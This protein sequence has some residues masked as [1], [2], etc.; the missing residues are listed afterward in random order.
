MTQNDA[1]FEAQEQGIS[2]NDLPALLNAY[3][4]FCKQKKEEDAKKQAELFP[5]LAGFCRW[6]G[7]GTE[8]FAKLEKLHPRLCDR[9]LAI[10]EDEALNS[11]LSSSTLNAYLKQR[12]WREED[13]RTEVNADPQL[14]LI[15]EHDILEDGK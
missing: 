4:E 3:L 14:R 12:L 15:F 2:A 9:I 5:N 11:Q 6:L 13:E 1:L 8:E 10:L 7:C